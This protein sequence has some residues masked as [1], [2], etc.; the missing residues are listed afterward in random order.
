MVAKEKPFIAIR[1]DAGHKRG[2]GHLFRMMTLAE[3]FKKNG[4]P[5]LFIIRANRIAERI[6]SEKNYSALPFQPEYSERDI[7]DQ[8]F[9]ESIHHPV[10]W[11]FDILSTGEELV[12]D[13]KKRGVPVV[14]FDDT[15]G[16]MG[17]ADLVINAISGCW[18]D[19]IPQN[20]RIL[21]GPRYAI[22]PPKVTSLQMKRKEQTASGDLVKLGITMGG[23]DTHGATI[24]IS[25][26]L[27]GIEGLHV[28][29]F[30][31]PH[32]MHKSELQNICGQLSFSYFIRHGVQDL[33]A[34]LIDMDIVLCGGG[35]TLFEICA[36][37]GTILALANEVHEKKTIAYFS[38]HGACIDL[39]YVKG[40]IHS[41]NMKTLIDGFRRDPEK[42]T[43][44]GTRAKQLVDGKGL[45]RCYKKCIQLINTTESKVC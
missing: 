13:V 16:G 31:G 29:Y 5:C 12:S 42:A 15:Q 34:E 37:G 38:K 35:Q 20:N 25:E 4:F 2:M 33:H 3:L 9:K 14:C 8:F 26:S 22:I 32:F 21:S 7:V 41:K 36:M 24:K 10:L 40:K 19:C 39:G 1:L 27:N 43:Q 11:I 45:E 30:L 23:S 18:S 6:L 28:Y 44:L 17:S